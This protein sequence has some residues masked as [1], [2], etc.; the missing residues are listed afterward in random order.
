MSR[1]GDWQ[2]T[3]A[4]RSWPSAVI[5]RHIDWVIFDGAPTWAGLPRGPRT[6]VS[7]VC[8]GPIGQKY[9][10][11]LLPPKAQ[12]TATAATRVLS[13]QTASQI[14]SLLP[15][16]RRR[17]RPAISRLHCSCT[18]WRPSQESGLI[19]TSSGRLPLPGR[20]R[21][22][23][24]AWAS[25]EAKAR[26]QRRRQSSWLMAAIT[27]RPE[28]TTVP[29]KMRLPGTGLPGSTTR[30]SAPASSQS[31]TSAAV[32]RAAPEDHQAASQLAGERNWVQVN[33][34]QLDQL[35][36]AGVDAKRSVAPM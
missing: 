31:T 24:R 18:W 6:P 16:S 32:G 8:T 27:S 23:P 12:P 35:G 13:N 5:V 1:Q 14:G 20:L 25:W 21:C 9:W 7:T 34:F 10:H 19:S 3:Q 36:R 29:Q 28:G 17:Q 2:A 26:G 11:Q 15:P 30:R 22:S 4:L 33:S